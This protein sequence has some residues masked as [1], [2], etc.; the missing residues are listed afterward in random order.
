MH[1][2]VSV[3]LDAPPDAVWAVIEPIESHVEWM[4]D[5]ERIT[6]VGPRRRGV[7]TEFDCRTRVGP[8]VTTDRMRVTAW[9]PG[10]AMGI[11][12]RG[13]VTGSGRFTLHPL[14]ASRTRF[15][16][17]E[18]LRFPAWLGGEIAATAAK[19]V[20]TQVWTRNLARLRARVA[21]TRP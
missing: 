9:D 18:D 8:F 6:F 14:G 12:H 1:I 11:E 10:R 21:A 16:W 2:S 3:D 19:P 7:G 20:L 15:R 5:A 4:A 17:E 13:L